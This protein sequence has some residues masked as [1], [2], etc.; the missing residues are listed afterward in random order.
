MGR[1]HQSES[2]GLRQDASQRRGREGGGVQSGC[3]L[4]T[5][6]APPRIRDCRS[7]SV[8]GDFAFSQ[9][10]AK[11]IAPLLCNSRDDLVLRTAI[12]LA[13]RRFVK[14]VLLSGLTWFFL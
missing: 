10:R 6:G 12:S 8:G 2:K 11:R 5:Q 9:R 14:D 3:R 4:L 7:E 1:E 13:L